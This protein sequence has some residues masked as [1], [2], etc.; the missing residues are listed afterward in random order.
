MASY[1]RRERV[2]RTV[3]FAIPVHWERG[4]SW[5]EIQKAIDAAAQELGGMTGLSDDSIWVRPGDDEIIVC[6]VKEQ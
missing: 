6:Y 4:A 5:A 2:T 3:E 1:T